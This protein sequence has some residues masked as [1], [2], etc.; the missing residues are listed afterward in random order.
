MNSMIYNVRRIFLFLFCGLFIQMN[1]LS[2]YGQ[3][4]PGPEYEGYRLYFHF[5]SV[6]K[7]KSDWILIKYSVI[8]TGRNEVAFG[9]GTSPESIVM[10]FDDKILETEVGENL[11]AF[12]NALFNSNLTIV[13]GQNLDKQEIKV[14]LS[15]STGK[16]TVSSDKKEVPV[17]KEKITKVK[18]EKVVKTKNDTKTKKEP[19]TEVTVEVDERLAENETVPSKEKEDAVLLEEV[20]IS[21]ET[22]SKPISKKKQKTQK[23]KKAKKSK[24]QKL[25]EKLIADQEKKA[26][27][28]EIAKAKEETLEEHINDRLAE[29]KEEIAEE[30]F[31]S[32]VIDE[33]IVESNNTKE[34][35]EQKV[36]AINGSGIISNETN[37]SQENKQ[38]E[39]E[40]T[41]EEIVKESVVVNEESIDIIEIEEVPNTENLDQ[42]KEDDK[43]EVAL[44][45]Q[46]EEEEDDGFFDRSTCA[47]LIVDSIRIIKNSKRSVTLEYTITNQG[48][49]PAKLYG[50]GKLLDDN[51]ALRAH[52]SSSERLTKGSIFLVGEY[53]PNRS[54]Q[55][56][57]APNESVSATIKLDKYKVT[58]F[59]P[60]VI[61]ELDTFQNVTECNETNNRGSIRVVE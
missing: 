14:L 46:T 4:N 15:P 3:D 11:D 48:A 42:E 1:A 22:I 6:V 60:Y 58:K 13:P 16:L 20:N 34:T 53:L 38:V 44:E 55:G 21:E 19:V 54:G 40:T 9:Q 41:T 29:E 25:Q 23:V 27:Q 17:K 61:L 28:L 51:L 10:N 52:L 56:E 18:K 12:R 33:E 8:N 36:I 57:L 7:K 24:E 59:T 45:S 35:E 37:S 32:N 49:G 30:D 2:A 50:K 26:K 47:D 31:D 39:V 5:A 43:K